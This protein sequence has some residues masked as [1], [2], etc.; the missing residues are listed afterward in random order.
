[1]IFDLD[2]T[3]VQ[4]ERLKAR[5]YAMAAV[6][7]RPDLAEADVVDGFR[8]FVGLSRQE[9][10]SGLIERFGLAPALDARRRAMGVSAAWQAFIQMRLVHYDALLHADGVLEA[11]RWPHNLALLDHARR[12]C[13]TVGLATMSH[14][15][16]ARFVLGRLALE[17]RFD[18][19]ASRDDV[20][21]GKPDPEIYLLVAD[22]L[23]AMPSACLV[24]EDSVAGA[25]AAR[26]AGMHCIAVGTPFTKDALHRSRVLEDRWIVDDPADVLATV[27][28]LMIETTGAPQ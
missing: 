18:F 15:R 9:V 20:D 24:I 4:T 10:A 25:T 3:L 27:R 8:E 14:C 17:D 28:Q 16:E 23:D 22:Q 21:Q 6:A 5:S 19:V 11:H 26:A 7:L 13:D 1:M 12:T 2:G